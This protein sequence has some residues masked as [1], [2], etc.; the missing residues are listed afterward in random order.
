[1]DSWT[2]ILIFIF[3]LCWG[4]FL[5]VVSARLPNV[6]SIIRH[7]SHCPKCKKQIKWYDLIPL[8]SFVVLARRCRFCKEPI[9]WHY[10][11]IELATGF[12][13][14]VLALQFGITLVAVVLALA[15]SGLLVIAIYDYFNMEI[16]EIIF[17][18]T[19]IFVVASVV[20]YG[21]AISQ[22]GFA[23]FWLGRII[24]MLV[25]GLVLGGLSFFG[26]GK[27]LGFGDVKLG[28]LLGFLLSY[29]ASL[30]GLFL[31]FIT[32]AIVGIVLIALKLKKSTDPVPFAPFLI[33]GSIV[34]LFWGEQ[35][36]LLYLTI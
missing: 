4:S 25:F 12:F 23:G 22:L 8:I 11:V 14:Y 24:G 29:P 34:A 27:W 16:E 1:M 30:V 17:W 10:P 3:G 26:K 20:V 13:F 36:L 5:N 15:I 28:L 31:G 9:S 33:F 2:L 18:I 35:L 32:G 19:T 7:R 6:E 21:S